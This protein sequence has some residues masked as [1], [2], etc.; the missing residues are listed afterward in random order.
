MSNCMIMTILYNVEHAKSAGICGGQAYKKRWKKTTFSIYSIFFQNSC[1][2]SPKQ[3]KTTYLVKGRN[4]L[5]NNISRY[6]IR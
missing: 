2:S 4:H 1:V 3:R 6:E 5:K